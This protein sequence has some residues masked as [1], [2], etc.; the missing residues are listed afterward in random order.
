MI[1][2][3]REKDKKSNYSEATHRTRIRYQ[4][5]SAI[6]DVMGTRPEKRY[7]LWRQ[8][9]WS[10]VKGS[11]ILEVGVRAGKNFP[12]YPKDT[13]VTAIDLTPGMLQFAFKTASVLGIDVELSLADVQALDFPNATFDS[14]VGSFVFCSV[15]NPV[16][17]LREMNRVVKPGGRIL[18]LEHVRSTNVVLGL[19]M[20]LLNPFIVRV[21]GANINRD[22]SKNIRRAGLVIEN[23]EFLGWQATY[24]LITARGTT[25][26]EKV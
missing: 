1:L 26:K 4:R 3:I 23:E 8:R 17:G 18:L 21:I 14:V 12:F 10:F 6:Y 2:L 25:N 22:T 5:I 24:R 16:L 15:P 7:L 20:D 9:L 11:R 13:R 19:M